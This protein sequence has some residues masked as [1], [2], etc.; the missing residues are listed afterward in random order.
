M[1]GDFTFANNVLF[2]WVHRTVDGGDHMSYY[3]IISNYFKPGPATPRG[4]PIT[5]RILKP[6]SERSKTVVD[7]FGK[8][9][10]AGNIVE[11][12]PRVSADNWDGGVQPDVRSKSL[13]QV[14][15]EIRTNTPYAYAPLRIQSADQSYKTVLATAGAT[16]PRRDPVDERV[17][18]MVLTGKVVKQTGAEPIPATTRVGFSEAVIAEITAL[19]G[20]GIIADP[21]QVG[22]YP[23]YTGKPYEDSDGDGL[24]DAWEKK[25]GLNPKDPT[26]AARD[27]DGDGYTNIEE[28]INGTDPTRFVDYTS[29]ENNIDSLN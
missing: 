25:H 13:A 22:G 16:R 10:V 19:V 5:H 21:A 6:E 18:K 26:D 24:P 9:Y 12:N 17:I 15:T 20:G 3:N 4:E 2:N 28:F 27:L 8:A 1:Y 29:L 11:G 14:F 23:E 7:H